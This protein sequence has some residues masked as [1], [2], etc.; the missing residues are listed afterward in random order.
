MALMTA[1]FVLHAPA[2]VADEPDLSLSCRQIAPIR[3]KAKFEQGED[4]SVRAVRCSS[5]TCR[6]CAAAT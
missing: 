2:G 1:L 5:R 6:W 3:I 4:V